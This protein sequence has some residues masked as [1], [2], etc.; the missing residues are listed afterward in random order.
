MAHK[1]AGSP[2]FA[3]RPLN[4]SRYLFRISDGYG[5]ERKW[6]SPVL[7]LPRYSGILNPLPLKPLGYEKPLP[8][9]CQIPLG[10]VGARLNQVVYD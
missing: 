10:I 6:A 8:H 2:G 9:F 5:N 7:C 4:N 1:V 3:I